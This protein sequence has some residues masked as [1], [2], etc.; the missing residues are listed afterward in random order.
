MTETTDTLEASFEAVTMAA[1]VARPVLA[2]GREASGAA[3]LTV[4]TPP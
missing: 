2:G 3:S 1:P 4:F